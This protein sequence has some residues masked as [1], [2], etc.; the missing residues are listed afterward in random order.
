M[1]S[2]MTWMTNWHPCYSENL[3]SKN[4]IT[5]L[6]YILYRSIFFNKIIVFKIIMIIRMIITLTFTKWEVNGSIPSHNI[7]WDKWFVHHI[8]KKNHYHYYH[9]CT[10]R[11]DF[12]FCLIY[13]L[14]IHCYNLS[15]FSKSKKLFN[16]FFI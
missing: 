5:H 3:F 12:F 6:I 11:I 16:I 10:W 14:K 9:F 2:T 4:N 15:I 1:M 8:T 13:K 7:G